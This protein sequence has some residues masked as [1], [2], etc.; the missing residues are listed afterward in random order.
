MA[1]RVDDRRGRFRSGLAP[2]PWCWG[3]TFTDACE[4]RRKAAGRLEGA[5]AAAGVRACGLP[6]SLADAAADAVDCSSLAFLLDASLHQRRKEEEEKARRVVME[7]VKAAMEVPNL[8]PLQ[9]SRTNELVEAMEAHDACKPSSGPGRR[10]KRRKR[11]KRRLPRIS[12]RPRLRGGRIVTLVALASHAL[13]RLTLFF[14]LPRG[15]LP[16]MGATTIYTGSIGSYVHIRVVRTTSNSLSVSSAAM[17]SRM[18]W[19][20]TGPCVILVVLRHMPCRRGLPDESC[21]PVQLTRASWYL[22]AHPCRARSPST[23]AVAGCAGL[24]HLLLCSSVVVRPKN[25]GNLVGM[26]QKDSYAARYLPRVACSWLVL[27]G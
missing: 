13:P 16:V 5:R 20:R 3:P 23:T 12:S 8:T 24:L 19:Q 21:T 11:R 9:K 17:V 7:Q 18:F 22:R 27:L 1:T 4:L 14:W 25:L 2:Q 15:T 10:T 6:P 26:D